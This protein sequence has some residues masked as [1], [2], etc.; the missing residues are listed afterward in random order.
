M[1]IWRFCRKSGVKKLKVT[2][3]TKISPPLQQHTANFL[4]GQKKS[5]FLDLG[6]LWT[7]ENGL[8]A[9]LSKFY[10]QKS[11]FCSLCNLHILC[12]YATVS[13]KMKGSRPYK[14]KNSSTK[15][16]F[17]LFFSWKT[18]ILCDQ[19]TVK[20]AIVKKKPIKWSKTSPGTNKRRSGVK[21]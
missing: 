3:T 1:L 6:R 16:N 10:I 18:T 15:I 7:M 8:R 9:F 2:I 14:L 4:W 5:P 19:I 21:N 13:E 17:S 20:T 12:C 11:S